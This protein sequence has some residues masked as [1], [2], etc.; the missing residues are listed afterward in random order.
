MQTSHVIVKVKKNQ[1]RSLTIYLLWLIKSLLDFLV[2]FYN[3]H[4][5]FAFIV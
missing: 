1:I 2:E 5:T 4:H 3:I